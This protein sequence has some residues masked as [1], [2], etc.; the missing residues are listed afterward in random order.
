MLIQEI[1]KI[2][3]YVMCNELEPLSIYLTIYDTLIIVIRRVSL[4]RFNL[5]FEFI[6]A[7]DFVAKRHRRRDF[8]VE[9]KSVEDDET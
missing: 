6:W 4:S 3:F 9:K 7:L 5:C 8:S 1:N 2:I